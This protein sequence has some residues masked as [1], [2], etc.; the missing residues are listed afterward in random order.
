M[1]GGAEQHDVADLT[2][3][4]HLLGEVV[5]RVLRKVVSDPG[6]KSLLPGDLGELPA[7]PAVAVNGFSQ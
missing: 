3:V 1:H 5:H 4:D 6:H 7:C 2:I